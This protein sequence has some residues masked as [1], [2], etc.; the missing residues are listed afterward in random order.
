[1]SAGDPDSLPTSKT[2]RAAH[3]T[4]GLAPVTLRLAGLVLAIAARN[5]EGAAG[6][7]ER[8]QEEL[9]DQALDVLGG[10]RGGAMKVGQLASFVDAGFLPPQYRA[11]WQRKLAGLRDSAP[12]M[13]WSA[14]SGVLEGEWD[15]PVE[16]LFDDFEHEAVAAASIGQVHRAVLPGGRRVAVKVQYPKIADALAADL[17]SAAMVIR[18]GKAMMPGLDAGQLAD[19]LRE[20]VLEEVDFELEA[21]HQ[22]AFARAYRGH[23]FVHVPAVVTGLSRRR[24]LVTAWV[25]GVRF[26][27]MCGL[28]EPD[29]DRIG[30]VVQRF[31][32]G[33][34]HR[35]GRFNT[36]PHPGNYLLRDDGSL[37]FL[38]FGN[39]K[40]VEAKTLR[41]LV[42]AVRAV[43][44][45]DA[46]RLT[47]QADEMGYVRRA[48]RVDVHALLRQTLAAG[49]WYYRDREL[50]IDPDYVARVLSEV[51]GPASVRHTL[52]LLRELRIPP[53]HIWLRRVETGV[54][55]VLGQLR[56]CANWHRIAREMWFADKPATAL[57]RAERDFFGT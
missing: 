34:M 33:S 40:V 10:L 55:G 3:A 35:I 49:D 14:V 2:A 4:A 29:R 16:S 24:V 37:A 51:A 1:M 56:A 31:Y 39:V 25:D 12:P 41:A 11:T 36:D 9:A 46:E 44:V 23:P 26:D 43:L 18:L 57:G 54:L 22:R 7:L 28:P 17:D 6:L 45:G 47:R 20:R 15:G 38:D 13:S 32:F 27:E 8:R 42:G 30:E 5:P 50:R 52:G 48:E 53:E 21:Q 19:E